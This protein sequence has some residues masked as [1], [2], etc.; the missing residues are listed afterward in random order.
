MRTLSS[1]PEPEPEPPEPVHFARSRSRSRSRRTVLLG[2]GAGAGA[3]LRPRSRSRS[4]SRPK[5]SRLRIP[6]GNVPVCPAVAPSDTHKSSAGSQNGDFKS[7]ERKTVKFCFE[8]ID[9]SVQVNKKMI[10]FVRLNTL[11]KHILH[12]AVKSL[13]V[14]PGLSHLFVRPF[15]R[16]S[17]F[18]I[19]S[20]RP[21]TIQP[22]IH[23]NHHPNVH[24]NLHPRRR[25]LVPP[26]P[27]SPPGRHEA[28]T[29]P[30]SESCWGTLCDR[31]QPEC[32]SAYVTLARDRHA[33]GHVCRQRRTD[34]SGDGA[35]DK[36]RFDSG[37]TC[38][39]IGLAASL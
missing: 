21:S 30:A 3:G 2:A 38:F 6:G 23:P 22:N 10:Y 28:L 14:A 5:M 11:H 1:E 35:P 24:P 36:R 26:P 18:P 39:R 29:S 34:R 8:N 27:A 16:P 9:R 32:A 17:S 31:T 19:P 33:C 15:R 20:Q 4:R 37:Q 13:P 12:V 7:C 25:P